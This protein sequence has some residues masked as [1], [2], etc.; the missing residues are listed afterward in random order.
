MERTT[1]H[2]LHTYDLFFGIFKGNTYEL[3]GR[4]NGVLI[5]H[6]GQ[7]A[8]VECPSYKQVAIAFVS[9][10]NGMRILFYQVF[11]IGQGITTIYTCQERTIERNI[12]FTYIYFGDVTSLFIED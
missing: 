7:I 4:F 8:C 2:P 10:L 3:M 11:E 5:I 6:T 1:S 12:T 9:S